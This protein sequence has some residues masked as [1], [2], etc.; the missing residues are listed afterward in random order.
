VGEFLE[1]HLKGN[2]LDILIVGERPSKLETI[3]QKVFQGDSG[4][5]FRAAIEQ[6]GIGEKNHAFYYLLDNTL[7]IS[8]DALQLR[9]AQ[10]ELALVIAQYQ[11]R[12]VIAVGALVKSVIKEISPENYGGFKLY[13]LPKPEWVLKKGGIHRSEFTTYVRQMKQMKGN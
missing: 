11:P 5:L 10:E 6:S 13:A 9:I 1:L 7:G 2:F 8:E 3:V 12:I 4:S